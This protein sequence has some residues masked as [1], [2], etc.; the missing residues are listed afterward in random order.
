MYNFCRSK[1]NKKMAY[2]EN[3]KCHQ[4]KF[5]LSEI[6]E[7]RLLRINHDIQR[8]YEELYETQER[9]TAL[10]VNQINESEHNKAHKMTC[11]PSEDSDQPGHPHGL[12]RV[13]VVRMK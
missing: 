11:A 1:S 7:R 13:F 4:K 5:T 9:L 8:V 12:I 6:L 3:A 2:G 10:R